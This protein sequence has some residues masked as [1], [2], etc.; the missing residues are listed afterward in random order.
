MPR[1]TPARRLRWGAALALALALGATACGSPAPPAPASGLA[2]DAPSA[3]VGA[4]PVTIEHK[5]GS[6]EITA[7]PQRVVLVGLN[8][9]DAL[10]ALGKVPVATSNFLDVDGGIFPWAEAALGGRPSRRCSTRPTGSPTR[11]SPS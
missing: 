6:T 7:E 5:Y 1:A 11:R 2:S 3:G 10:L 4:Y 9:Q 8:E